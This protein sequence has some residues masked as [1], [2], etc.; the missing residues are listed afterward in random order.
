MPAM[1]P[2]GGSCRLPRN[3]LQAVAVAVAVAAPVPAMGQAEPRSEGPK[4]ALHELV[5]PQVLETDLRQTTQ[6]VRA[7]EWA[8]GQ[9]VRVVEDLREEVG[10]TPPVE[11]PPPRRAMAP[12]LAAPVAGVNFDGISATGVLPPDTVGDVGPNHYIQMVN[13]AFTIYDKAG[14]LLAGPTLI[15]G[16][17]SQFGGPCE[18]END[19]DPIVRYDHLADR[20]LL[21]QFAVPGGPQGLHECI[22]VS[23]TADP[24]AGGWFLYDFPTVDGTTGQPVFPD[25][26]KIGVWPDAYYMGTQRGFPNSGLDVWA[27]DRASM[28]VGAPAGLVQFSVPRPSLFLMPADLDGP[29]PPAGTPNFFLRQVDG[30]RFG[31]GDRLEVFAFAVDWSNPAASTFTQIADLPTAP[32]DSVLCSADLLGACIPQPGVSQRLETLTVWPMWRLQYRNFGS[33]EAMVVNHTVDANG[34][35]LAGIRWYELRRDPAGSWGIFQQGTL[36]PDETHRWMGSVAMDRDGNIALGYSVASGSVFPGLRQIGRLAT[37]P[38]GTLPQAETDIIVGSGA[39]THPARRWGNYSSMDVDPADGCTFWYTSEYYSTTSSAGWQTRIASFRYPSCGE[40]EARP[41]AEL[42]F[43]YP[44]K[45]VCGLQ[46]DPKEMKLV[47]GFYGSAINIYN[48]GDEPVSLRKELALTFPPEEEGPGKVLKIAEEQLGSGEALEVDCSDL[49]REV[50]AGQLPE[51]Y[52]KG[53]VAI[54]SSGPLRVTGVY[55]AAG[56]DREDVIGDVRSV[57]VEEIHP[58]PARKPPP[59]CPD[60]TIKDIGQPSVSCP[61]G[62]GTCVTTVSYTVANVGAAAASSFSVRTV[63][64]PA[65]SVVVDQLLASGLG[66]GVEQT[67]TVITPPGGNCFDPDCTV[68]VKAD[69]GSEVQECDEGNNSAS[70][71]TPG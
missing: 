21:S 68:A 27:F 10:P 71:T 14:N 3:L 13:S 59:S 38:P 66:A 56:L 23:R 43:L 61:G 57:D 26:P 9:S 5:S 19:G 35:D 29:P 64:D 40:I 46:P 34:Q 36:A 2:F 51:R 25:Y 4:P 48:P 22:A 63:L 16:L 60:L 52:I 69:S 65:A 30:D 8:E 37:D 1:D 70:N 17:W 45:V 53:F 33:H 15:K 39:Q 67:M 18:S 58:A 31:G 6:A 42:P 20:W 62:A 47:R 50:F 24:V 12:E 49:S 44:A 41:E 32:F 28:L 7:L 11:G 54:R 55:T